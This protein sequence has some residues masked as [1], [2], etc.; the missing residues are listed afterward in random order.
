[1]EAEE[2]RQRDGIQKV[3]KGFDFGPNT[4]GCTDW[5]KWLNIIKG[6]KLVKV[7]MQNGY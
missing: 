3:M 1:M 7:H 2:I 4:T 6:N 5:H